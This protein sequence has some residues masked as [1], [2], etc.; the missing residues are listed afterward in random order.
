MK[1]KNRVPEEKKAVVYQVPCKDCHQLYTGESKRT[2]KVRLAEHKRAVQK[3]DG[4]AVH[5]AN[6]NHGIDWTNAR[7]M[8]TVPEYW[9]RR[10]TEV[11]LIKKSQEPMNLDSGLLLPSV[12]N[13]ILL[14]TPSLPH[15]PHNDITSFFVYLITVYAINVLKCLLFIQL[16]SFPHP[17][18]VDKEP[19]LKSSCTH[20][21][22]KLQHCLSDS[23]CINKH[24][25]E[26]LWN[27][28]HSSCTV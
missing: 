28:I 1:V 22:K 6:T 5:V 27:H 20:L 11:I 23:C 4:I 8:K 25:N 12:W 18:A 10:T 3:S 17:V 2:L 24:S 19:L 13:L 7:V 26:P 21:Y 15:P 14:N 16:I 9:E